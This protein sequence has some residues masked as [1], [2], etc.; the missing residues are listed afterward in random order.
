[1]NAQ[2]VM[3]TY[4]FQPQVLSLYE[5]CDFFPRHTP[6]GSYDAEDI[7]RLG[8]IAGLLGQVGL[9]RDEAEQYLRS[10]EQGEGKCACQKMLRRKRQELLA[11]VHS[12]ERCISCLDEISYAL[13]K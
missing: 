11:E 1:M 2:E 4:N 5:D 12:R 3:A 9:S 8:E 10:K 6:S 7:R 13:G